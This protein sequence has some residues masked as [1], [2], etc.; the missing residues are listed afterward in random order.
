MPLSDLRPALNAVSDV[1]ANR[2]LPIREF[3]QIYMKMGDLVVHAEFVARRMNERGVAFVGD[4][5]AVGLAIA[6]LMNEG[7]LDRGPS[8]ILVLDFDERVVRSIERF[9]ANYGLQD[10]IEARLY[11]VVDAVPEE[12]L[13]AYGGFH[14]NPPWGQH[15]SGESVSVFLERAIQ[16]LDGSGVGIVV[17]AD[18]PALAWT[19]EVLRRT[20]RTALE[21]GLIVDEM[22][23]GFHQYHLDDA[24]E[25]RSCCLIF[26]QTEAS[27]ITNA[28]LELQR[29]ENFYGRTQ[30]LRV[31]YV[32]DRPGVDVG[33]A[34]DRSYEFE[35]IGAEHD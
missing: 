15:N 34:P 20:Q 19:N 4:G 1:I 9:A 3:D 23:P 30:R 11:N 29:M 18:D 13:S 16:L 28:P 26:R 22:I 31:H 21:R 2:P 17:I 6:H 12:L 33:T 7:I 5:D 32:R 27:L 24:P 35:L 14:I 25:L 10:R 8:K